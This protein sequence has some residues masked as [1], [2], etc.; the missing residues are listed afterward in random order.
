M[1][2]PVREILSQKGHAIVTIAPSATVYE[3]VEKMVEKNVGS[4]II[5]NAHGKLAGI[6]VERDCFRKV[7][8]AGKEA[9]KTLVKDV[10]NPI[11]TI[12][13][14]ALKVDGAAPMAQVIIAPVQ[15]CMAMVGLPGQAAPVQTASAV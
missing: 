13:G 6:F 4:L 14:V 2:T 8:L 12:L 9:K 3:A 7:I 15:Q 5:E 1:K 11:I 10:E